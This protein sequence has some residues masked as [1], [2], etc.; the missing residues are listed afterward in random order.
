MKNGLRVLLIVLVFPTS[1]MAAISDY[2][3]ETDIGDFIA[4]KNPSEGVGRGI[5]AGA[6]HFRSRSR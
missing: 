5:L 3:I 1:V 6:D 2:L 4:S